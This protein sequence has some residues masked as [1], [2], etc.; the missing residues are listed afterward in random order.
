MFTAGLSAAAVLASRFSTAAMLTTGLS[1][2]SLASANLGMGYPSGERRLRREQ[3]DRHHL[4]RSQVYR[5]RRAEFRPVR[6]V[7]LD[8]DTLVSTLLVVFSTVPLKELLGAS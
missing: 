6:Q 2:T 7:D 4:A 8:P 3:V 1:A 5:S